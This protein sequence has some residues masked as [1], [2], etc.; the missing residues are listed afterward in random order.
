[1]CITATKEE[2]GTTTGLPSIR[3]ISPPLP[4]FSPRD[5]AS[6]SHELFPYNYSAAADFPFS[7][8]PYCNPMAGRCNGALK[9]CGPAVVQWR[10]FHD[11]DCR[12]QQG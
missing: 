6:H 2:E 8:L 4:F 3:D 5:E 9:S 1:M 7:F 12:T 11:T 10:A